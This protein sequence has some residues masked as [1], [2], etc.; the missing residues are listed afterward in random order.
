MAQALSFLLIEDNTDNRYLLVRT[1][2][3]KFPGAVTI[4]CSESEE[5]I[6]YLKAH[7]FAAIILH[8]ASDAD[9]LPMVEI[10]R[11]KTQTPVIVVSDVDRS[12]KVLAAGATGFLHYDAWLNLGTVVAN[13]L[14]LASTGNTP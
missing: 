3:R 11:A 14:K 9:A 8:R 10:L 2:N 6:A 5:A 7:N 13:V 12:E 4:E 1:L